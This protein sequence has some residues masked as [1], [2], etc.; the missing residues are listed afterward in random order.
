M[1]VNTRS[2]VATVGAYSAEHGQDGG[3]LV[4]GSGFGILGRRAVEG[5]VQDGGLVDDFVDEGGVVFGCCVAILA[6]GW[7]TSRDDFSEG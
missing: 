2:L 4:E 5:D 3:E 7:W 6:S 1:Q